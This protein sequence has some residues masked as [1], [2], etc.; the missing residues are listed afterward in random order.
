MLT[1]TLR[2]TKKNFD[3]PEVLREFDHGKVELVTVEDVTLARFTLQPG[4]KWSEAIR[5]IAKTEHCVM[6]H[7]Q[8]VISG[9][10]RV[11]MEDGEQMDFG[12]G[13]F[14]SIPPGH[15]AWILGDEPFVG[16]DF[17]PDVRQYAEK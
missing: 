11:V 12:P 13:D 2:L 6:H 7:A 16:I 8:C 15:D 3:S 10:L 17:S 14:A 1:E 9:R 4:W 5:P